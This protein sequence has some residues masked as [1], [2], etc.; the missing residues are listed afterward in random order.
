[1]IIADAASNDTF[2]ARSQTIPNYS[3]NADTDTEFTQ[4]GKFFEG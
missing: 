4:A 3:V 1:M 2:S